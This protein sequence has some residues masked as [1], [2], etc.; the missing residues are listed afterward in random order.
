MIGLKMFYT[1]DV[2][3][4]IMNIFVHVHLIFVMVIQLK[5]YAAMMIVLKLTY[6]LLDQCV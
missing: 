5:A 4:I 6:V 2:S 3:L 1:M